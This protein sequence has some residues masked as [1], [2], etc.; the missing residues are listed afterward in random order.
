MVP[1]FN[2]IA[3]LGHG[4]IGQAIKTYLQHEGYE[5]GAFDIRHQ[6]GVEALDPVDQSPAYFKAVI[7]PYD[8]VICATPYHLNLPIARAAIETGKAY[9]DLTEDISVAAHIREMAKVESSKPGHGL[10]W[11]TPQCGLAPGAVNMI[12]N[13][14]VSKF[15][16]VTDINIRVGALP[17][18]TN[19][20]MKYYLT[21]SS[22]GLVNEYCNP[23][24]A[25]VNGKKVMLQPLEGYEEIVIDGVEYE[26][27]NTSGGIGTLIDTLQTAKTTAQN[28]N[29][30]TMRYKGH[31]DLMAFLLQDLGMA[32]RQDVLVDIFN[33]AIPQVTADVI[34]IFI[35]VT[36]FKN[37]AL[38]A[39]TYCRKIIGDDQFTAIQRTTAAGVC[40]VV[41]HWATRDWADSYN[42]AMEYWDK[43]CYIRS[44]EHIA[45]SELAGNPFWKVYEV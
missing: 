45:L 11:V 43:G 2:K 20:Q 29:Y 10:V 3:L 36:G 17:R 30:K 41:H 7:A 38:K 16:S 26:A 14:T 13:D 25:L 24:E 37:G 12:A 39:L 35:Q 31:R 23:C 22:E 6:E 27:F 18:T 40:A 4:R 8:G 33:R 19:N 15:D 34:V 44:P 32:T 1:H 42:P 9:F 28:I 21:W 5:V